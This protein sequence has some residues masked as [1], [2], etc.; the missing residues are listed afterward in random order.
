MPDVTSC[1]TSAVR[2]VI[3]PSNGAVMTP[4]F[5]KVRKPSHV[6]ERAPVRGFRRL[7]VRPLRVVSRL[8]LV[9][10]LLRD[11]ASRSERA[12]AVVVCASASSSCVRACR[13]SRLDLIG[14][15]LALAKLFVDV[16]D[17]EIDERLPLLHMRADIDV[18]L[19][20]VP[21]RARVDARLLQRLHRSGERVRFTTST[22]RF[23]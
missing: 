12:V 4:K 11:D 3:T 20:D 8:V 6:R 17:I 18:P 13:D 19:A 10:L 14:R 21:V 15:G 16:G 9:D 22:E 2:S 1:P 23:A 7:N 5:R